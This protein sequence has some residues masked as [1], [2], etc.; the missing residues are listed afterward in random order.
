MNLLFK[1]IKNADE[2]I[3]GEYWVK[4][5]K[6]RD[7]ISQI[8]QK[9][10]KLLNQRLKLVVDVGKI[11]QDEKSVFYVPSREQKVYQQLLDMNEGPLTKTALKAIYREIMSASLA[12]EKNLKIGYL[13]R[14]GAFYSSCSGK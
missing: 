13:G 10:L 9:I 12:L 1:K 8:D 11:K 2:V 14:E 4:L 7:N 5:E 6:I 3:R